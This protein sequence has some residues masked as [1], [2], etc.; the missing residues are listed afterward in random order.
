MQDKSYQWYESHSQQW[1]DFSGQQDMSWPYSD[2][3]P[4]LS[5]NSSILDLG[6]GS[7]RDLTHFHKRGFQVEGLE[8]SSKLCKIAR[9]KSQVHVIQQDFNELTLESQKYDGIFAN[10]VLMHVSPDKREKFINQIWKSLKPNGVFYAHF[11]KGIK[12]EFAEDG[13]WL[14]LTD[15]WP[16]LFAKYDWQIELDE[17]RP[18]FLSPEEQNWQVIRYRK[19]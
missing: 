1:I 8:G 19:S 6:C 10:A 2:F 11:P 3:L 7:G 12:S 15:M 14:H 16:S 13:R 9:E 18:T 4:H 5:P 17:G